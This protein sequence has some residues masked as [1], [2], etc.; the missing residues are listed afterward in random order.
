MIEASQDH[1]QLIDRQGWNE[2]WKS[3]NVGGKAYALVA[4]FYRKFIIRPNLNRFIHKYFQSGSELIHAG[5]GSGEVDADLNQSFYLIGLDI[6][7]EALKRYG[8]NNTPRAKTLHASIFK[9][10]FGDSTVTGLYN[11]GVMEHFSEEEIGDILQEFR[12]VLKPGGKVVLFWPPE[13]GLSVLFFKTLC[14]IYLTVT[15]KSIK[16]HPDEITRL[17][18]KTHAKELLEKNGFRMVEYSFGMRDVFT[19]GI[20]VGEPLQS[21]KN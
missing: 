10:P 6:S 1:I 16:F 5:C 8:T 4:E 21:T 3:K 11:L 7:K 2:Y 13:Y 18:S 15:G 19:Y 9:M 17:K 14:K 12:R 20:V